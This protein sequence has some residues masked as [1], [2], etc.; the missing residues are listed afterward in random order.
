MGSDQPFDANARGVRPFTGLDHPC[1]PE[2]HLLR[3]AR[4]R[5]VAVNREGPAA[6]KYDLRRLVDTVQF[7]IGARIHE[8][9]NI[10]TSRRSNLA[11]F[12]GCVAAL[13]QGNGDFLISR[14][15]RVRR[16]HPTPMSSNKG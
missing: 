13:P 12:V 10:F 1:C 9:R 4:Q 5:R 8:T 3:V 11:Q 14:E 15:R 2:R 6:H 16:D 7:A